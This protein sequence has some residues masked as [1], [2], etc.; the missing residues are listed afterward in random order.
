MKAD[1]V[2]FDPGTIRDRAT[3]ENP[4]RYAEGVSLVV[5]NG[6]VVLEGERMTGARPGRV[7]RGPSARPSA[8]GAAG[9][10]Y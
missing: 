10:A 8:P 5:V 3:F 1:L 7:L 4:H 6:Q 2:V 9:V